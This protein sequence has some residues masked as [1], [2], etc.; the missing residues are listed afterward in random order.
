MYL[1]AHFNES[2]TDV[3]AP[4]SHTVRTGWMPITSHSIWLQEKANSVY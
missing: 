3:L 4:W 1:P 2:R